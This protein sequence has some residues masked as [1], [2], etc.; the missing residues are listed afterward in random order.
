MWYLADG[1]HSQANGMSEKCLRTLGGSCSLTNSGA[2]FGCG[3]VTEGLAGLQM[4][5]AAEG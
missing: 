3:G 1:S 5:L 4:Q 2:V